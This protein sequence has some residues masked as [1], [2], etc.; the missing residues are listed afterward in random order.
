VERLKSQR[1]AVTSR[2]IG[3]RAFSKA[4]EPLRVPL[5]RE[6]IKIRWAAAQMPPSKNHRL[7]LLSRLSERVYF[8]TSPFFS[9]IS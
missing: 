4:T 3:R 1:P 9:L 5:R 6:A 8:L 7:V 2:Q